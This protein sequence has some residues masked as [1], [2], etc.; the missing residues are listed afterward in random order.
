MTPG[1]LNR[2]A[3]AD[4]EVDPAPEHSLEHF[5]VDVRGIADGDLDAARV[6]EADRDDEHAPRNLER[7]KSCRPRIDGVADQ[8]D[9]PEAGLFRE[10]GG[11]L[12]LEEPA[13]GKEGLAEATKGRDDPSR[14]EPWE[15]VV[16]AL[17]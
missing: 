7:Q 16:V 12:G 4:H 3:L 13:P 15:G 2:R 8:I 14:L 5:D 9:I 17:T 1:V 6:Q 11:E 10:G